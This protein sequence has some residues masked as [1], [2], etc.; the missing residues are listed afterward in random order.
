M[1]AC[2]PALCEQVEADV[3]E[4]VRAAVHLQTPGGPQTQLGGA[5]Y[6]R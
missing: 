4:T 1:R 3:Q 2:L 5:A 6:M